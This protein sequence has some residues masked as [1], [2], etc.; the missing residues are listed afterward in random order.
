[1]ESGIRMQMV[2]IM[3]VDLQNIDG[4]KYSFD[5]KWIYADRMGYKRGKGL[6][7]SMKMVPMM[8]VRSAR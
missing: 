8:P 2:H 7:L 6:L 3:Q 4:V 1:M 5:D